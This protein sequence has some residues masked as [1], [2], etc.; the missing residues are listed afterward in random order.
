MSLPFDLT[1][2][3]TSN[4]QIPDNTLF[5]VHETS[6]RLTVQLLPATA[7]SPTTPL[8]ANLSTVPPPPKSGTFTAANGVSFNGTFAAAEILISEPTANFPNPFIYVS[9]RNLGPDLDPNGDTIAIFQFQRPTATVAEAAA[10]ASII[11]NAGS[12]AHSRFFSRR[13]TGASNGQGQLV[14]VAQ[15]HTGLS[16][17]RSM[18]LGTG[19]DG[20]DQYLIAG[21]NTQGGVAIFQRIDGGKNLKLVARNVEVQNRTSFVFL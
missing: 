16:Q 6:S 3:Y 9:N 21:A 15:V 4:V 12:S 17:I 2:S 18:A 8:I 7:T 13:Q 19:T 5:T 11:V 20:A 10:A 1:A 14:L